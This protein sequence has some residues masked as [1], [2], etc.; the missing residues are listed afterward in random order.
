MNK[1]KES[2]LQYCSINNIDPDNFDKKN[3][4]YNI[5]PPCSLLGSHSSS[6]I[7]SIKPNM[8]EYSHYIRTPI[9]KDIKRTAGVN[10]GNS[11]NF[12]IPNEGQSVSECILHLKISAIKS[13]YDVKYVDYPGNKILENI[14]INFLGQT[15]E[16][17]PELYNLKSYFCVGNS[18]KYIGQSRPCMEDQLNLPAH[19]Q[20]EYILK[21][22]ISD[23]YQTYKKNHE[24]LEL[25]IFIYLG[26]EK[27]SSIPLFRETEKNNINI[28]AKITK[29]E[30]ILSFRTISGKDAQNNEREI[31]N[32]R[33]NS[34]HIQLCE[35]YTKHI[36]MKGENWMLTIS[37]WPDSIMTNY[38][39]MN[40]E[41][42]PPDTSN[43]TGT[44][45][46]IIKNCFISNIYVAFKP[47]ENFTKPAYWTCNSFI[48]NKPRKIFLNNSAGHMN[49]SDVDSSEHIIC[50][51]TYIHTKANTVAKLRLDVSNINNDTTISGDT[52]TIDYDV[53]FL[54]Y[55][56]TP[57][58]EDFGPWYTFAGI[59]ANSSAFQDLDKK[60][61]FNYTLSKALKS[62]NVMIVVIVEKKN[63]LH[64]DGESIFKKFNITDETKIF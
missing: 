50:Y 23:G 7:E 27:G 22:L 15:W 30:N 3:R 47:I 61:T 12:T 16:Y 1:R 32:A 9:T 43:W 4:V 38:E 10:F 13:K 60:I 34:C 53:S 56:N 36:F 17:N 24:E 35:F 59:T 6:F 37:K 58:N 52:M 64:I 5:L 2:F 51:D 25:Y 57:V 18:N 20:K 11:I 49:M 31:N 14:K 8:G 29:L 54:D 62:K 55:V 42:S 39:I 48:Q 28:V 33:N 46:F 41:I 19:L 44:H 40:K 63:I 21:D 26:I 45:S